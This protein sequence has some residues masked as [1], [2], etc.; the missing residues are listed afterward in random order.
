MDPVEN[1]LAHF[2]VK[3][4]KW[5]VRKSR[6]SGGSKKQV[7]HPK[8]ADAAQVHEILGTI[9]KHGIGAA[10][11]SDLQL[12]EKRIKLETKFNDAFPKKKTL[13]DHGAELA[14]RILLPVAEQQARAFLNEKAKNLIGP[15]TSVPT[16][17]APV[18]TPSQVSSVLKVAGS[19]KMADQPKVP[20]PHFGFA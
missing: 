19:H 9:H 11:N 12:L 2:G 4:M 8:T 13:V 10:S 6:S 17:K 7:A 5:G 1:V 20:L 3:G 16:T 15:G 18:T 14:K